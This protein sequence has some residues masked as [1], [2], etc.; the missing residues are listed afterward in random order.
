M[1]E[2]RFWGRLSDQLIK[3][4]LFGLSATIFFKIAVKAF[5]ISFP[6][7]PEVN[8]SQI[9]QYPCLSENV[10]VTL[11]RISFFYKRNCQ[12]QLGKQ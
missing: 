1:R 12:L 9:A 3:S 10:V 5:A 6:A 8:S 7:L 11:K 2:L 4:I